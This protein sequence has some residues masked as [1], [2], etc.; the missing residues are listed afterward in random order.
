MTNNTETKELEK[1]RI[2]SLKK[3]DILDTP[4]DG[5]FDRITKLAAILLEVPIAIVTLVDTD[6]IWFKSKYGL[7]VQ[8]IGRDPGLCASAILAD[9][10]YEVGD[11]LTDPRTLANPLVAS[12][13]GLRFYAAVPLKVKDGYNLGTLCVLDKKPR[14]LTKAQKETLQ[15]LADITIDQMELRLSARTAIFQQNQVLSIAAHDLKNPL[16]TVTAWADLAK[17]FKN[18]PD[19]VEDM[20]DRIKKSADKMNRL[21]NDLLES[22]RKDANEVQ[23]RPKNLDLAVIIDAVVKA[24]EVL[25]SNKIISLN[26][27]I[28][29]KPMITGDEDRITELANNLVNNAIKYS[30]YGKNV[31]VTLTSDTKNAILEVRDEGQGLTEEDKQN[32]FQRFVTLS[33]Q[34]TGGETSTG[35]GLSIVKTF[36]EAHGGEIIVQSD[37]K[38][39][40][41]TFIVKL[42]LIK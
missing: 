6:R 16:T 36:V 31:F 20:C 35:L 40:G 22:A 14:Q 19:R 1:E 8:Q 18:D 33:A 17:Q 15:Y 10:L 4:P 29:S 2:K 38:S 21:V 37:G 24:N 27:N 9:D 26:L 41:A 5:S 39:T 23:V 32:L 25:A 30:P 13:F 3:Y 7:D 34:P 42:P 11:T 28:L 12:D